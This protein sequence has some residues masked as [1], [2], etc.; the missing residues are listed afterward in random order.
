MTTRKKNRI[1]AM[2]WVVRGNLQSQSYPSLILISTLWTS[3]AFI[4]YRLIVGLYSWWTCAFNQN[5]HSD[6]RWG[7]KIWDIYIWLQ[8]KYLSITKILINK[9][10]K[11]LLLTISWF[12]IVNFP[13]KNKHTHTPIIIIIKYID[14]QIIR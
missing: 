8:F 14:I 12:R 6:G 11:F 5:D 10:R 3:S 4:R 2:I 1:N 9:K 13:I 7:G